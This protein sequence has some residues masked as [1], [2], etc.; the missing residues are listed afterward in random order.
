[1]DK[2][3]RM[4]VELIR[5]CVFLLALSGA[6]FFYGWGSWWYL[7]F[8]ALL[9]ASYNL[10]QIEVLLQVLGEEKKV[11]VVSRDEVERLGNYKLR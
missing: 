1:M 5:F 11:R 8:V 7:F 4:V 6:L 2:Q 9:C 10:L 3:K